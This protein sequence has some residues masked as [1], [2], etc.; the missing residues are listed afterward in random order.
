MPS[1]FPGMDPFLESPHWFPSLHDG[2]IFTIVAGLHVHLPR[3]YY[4]TPR[5]RVWLEVERR[6]AVEPA[7]GVLK[8]SAAKRPTRKRSANRG[9]IAVAEPMTAPPVPV[10]VQTLV[11]DPFHEQYLEIHR[12]QGKD[13]TVVAIVEILSP[14]NKTPGDHGRNL[15]ITE[16]EETLLSKVHLIEIDLL[17]D[18]THSTAVP[19]D[20]A[21]AEAGSFDYHA[22]VHRADQFADFFVYPVQLESKLPVISVLLLPGD[23]DVPLDLQAA[24]NQVYDAGPYDRAVRYDLARI[25]PPLPAERQRWLKGRLAGRPL[26]VSG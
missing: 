6:S 16:Q 14:S 11:G 26:R 7:M 17:R 10:K 25:K 13:D 1:P 19:L 15:Y 5:Q 3:S 2:L 9:G 21:T 4:A 12:R 22:C 18:G 20:Q 24:F 8:S 23:A